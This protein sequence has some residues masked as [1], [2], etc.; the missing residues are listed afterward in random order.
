M[1]CL[2]VLLLGSI[3]FGTLCACWTCISISFT[4]VRKFSFIIFSN[5]FSV[6][7]SLCLWHY[8]DSDIAMFRDVPEASL[9]SSFIWIF[10]PSWGQVE[11]LF[12][13]YVPTQWFESRLLPIHCWFPVDLSLFP[14]VSSF[15][16][17]PYSVSSL[18]TLITSVLNSWSDRCV[19]SISFSLFL[20]FCSVLSLGPYFFASSICQPLYVCFCVLSRAAL[21]S[22]P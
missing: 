10:I 17:L 9:L 12:P 5:K 15:M 7:C 11:C 18:S 6:S 19:I 14:L 13:P 1:I 16:L 3:L 20:E 8:Y 2:G 22:W 4:K 21:S